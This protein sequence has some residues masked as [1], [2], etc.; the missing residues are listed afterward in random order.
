MKKPLRLSFCMLLAT[1]A[2]FAGSVSSD[3]KG[4]NS[5]SGVRVL[6]RFSSP[7]SAA[8]LN[9]IAGNG[10]ALHKQFKHMPKTAVFN[11]S[12]G[13]MKKIATLPGVVY[14]TP[15]RQLKR[16]L[17]LTAATVGATLAQQYGFTGV[18]GGGGGVDSGGGGGAPRLRRR[19]GFGPG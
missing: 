4:M 6:V 10:A 14:V 17:D 8:L 5:G 3:L 7:P 12:V 9:Q 2:A 1:A 13:A 18:G 15:D 11:G 19:G 16:K